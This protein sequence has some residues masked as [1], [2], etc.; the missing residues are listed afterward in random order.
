MSNKFT[1][2]FTLIELL[3]VIS[4][5]GLLSSVVLASLETARD[6]GRVAGGLQ[7]QT[8][9]HR[10]YGSDAIF[11]FDFDGNTIGAVKDSLG[12]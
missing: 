4:I 8:S 12:K 5:I 1:K 9:I 7:A 3:V 10:A 2:G 6:K 11:Y